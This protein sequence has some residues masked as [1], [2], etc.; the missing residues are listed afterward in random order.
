MPEAGRRKLEETNVPMARVQ[1]PA[2]SLQPPASRIRT[3]IIG[4]SNIGDAIL[5][6]DVVAA[7]SARHPDAHLTL[8][9]GRR[10]KALFAEDPRIHTLV[11]ADAFASGSGRLRLAL[12]LW[13]YHPHVLVDLRHTLY[14]LLLKP[15]SAWRY[16]RQP[17]RG[18]RH[19]R[20]R[21]L[22]RL[23]V[24]APGIRAGQ[25][26]GPPALRL[27]DKDLAHVNGLWR[28]WQLD[29]A[30]R[31]VIIC[32]GARSHIKRWTAE[33]FARVA[34][35]LIAEAG[36]TVI[37]SGEPEEKPVID[38]IAGAMGR[39]AHSAV[40][41]T[42]IR[43]LGGLMQ[44]AHLVVTNDSASLHLASAA[45]VP[46]LAVFGPTDEA[47]YGP[48]APRHRT[49]RRRLFCAPCERSLCRFNHECMRFIRADEVYDAA[50]DLLRPQTAD[51]RQQTKPQTPPRDSG[52]P[53]P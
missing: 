3:L 53:A 45:R 35:R 46:T 32:P 47:K 7:V 11:D 34:D 20:E 22:W 15:L 5:A 37:L 12:A 14:P 13:R 10:A 42:T 26:D 52:S 27:T 6:S 4:P 48:A 28:R 41:L 49:I 18:L 29:R 39:R 36:A 40:G 25:E 38:E 21:H 2:S 51:H 24:Q 44:R 30:E 50:R 33:G 43:Q 16:L 31:I 9:V 8:V 1:P 23:A 17:P 19:M